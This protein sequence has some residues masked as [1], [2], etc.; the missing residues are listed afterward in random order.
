MCEMGDYL[1]ITIFMI[2]SFANKGN[3]PIY[4]GRKTYL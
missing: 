2:V 3:Q 1:Y 4:F